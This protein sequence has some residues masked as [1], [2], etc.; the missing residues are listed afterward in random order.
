MW[1]AYKPERLTKAQKAAR[2]AEVESR[3]VTLRAYAERACRSHVNVG[4]TLSAVMDAMNEAL[5][6]E[7]GR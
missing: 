3:L 5:R 7:T 4:K 6:L 1:W 2:K